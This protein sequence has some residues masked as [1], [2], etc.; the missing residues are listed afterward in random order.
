MWLT[1][2]GGKNVVAPVIPETVIIH[3]YEKVLK[4]EQ[5][6]IACCEER[7]ETKYPITVDMR[8][9]VADARGVRRAALALEDCEVVLFAHEDQVLCGRLHNRCT[10]QSTTHP[11]PLQMTFQREGATQ[12]DIPPI[13]AA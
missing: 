11:S 10:K 6:E 1:V 4:G 2:G 3:P 5:L 12:C 13:L 8:M 7:A 9:G